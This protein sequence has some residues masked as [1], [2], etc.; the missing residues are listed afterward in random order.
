MGMILSLEI[1]QIASYHLTSGLTN[2]MN[3]NDFYNLIILEG[4]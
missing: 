3:N 1:V 2:F 4:L